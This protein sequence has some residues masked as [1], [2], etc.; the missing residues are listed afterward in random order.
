MRTRYDCMLD[1][2]DISSLSPDI[3][4]LDVQIET[5]NDEITTSTL[6][7]RDGQ[8]MMHRRT[9]AQRVSV[10]FEIHNQ[11]VEMRMQALDAVRAWASKGGYLTIRDMPGKRLYVICDSLPALSSALKW[12]QRLTVS[13]AAYACPWWEDVSP[14]LVTINGNGS[15][16]VFVPGYAA[17]CAVEVE[18]TNT[19]SAAVSSVTVT[20]GST[21]M[22]FAGLPLAS[23]KTL[24]I[25]T[26]ENGID[27]ARIDGAG[28]LA[29]RTPESADM[30][31]LEAGKTQNLAVSANGTVTA[32]FKIRGRY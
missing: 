18:V 21:V 24:I 19:G 9:N 23:G 26:D 20:A 30:L 27:Y 28:V 14:T 5:P 11:N 25:G 13:F 1:G 22:T 29:Y 10:A 6:A 16:T 2:I 8:R 17:P 4:L 12:T 7:G 15:K 3:Y 31:S 32:K